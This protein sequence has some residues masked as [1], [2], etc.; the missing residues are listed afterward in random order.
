MKYRNNKPI[1]FIGGLIIIV[2]LSLLV[3]FIQ[4]KQH[5]VQ[6]VDSLQKRSSM[7]EEQLQE[8]EDIRY[9]RNYILFTGDTSAYKELYITYYGLHN[10]PYS[11]YLADHCNYPYACYNVYEEISERF[12]DLEDP[13]LQTKA[14]Q[15]A[16]FY[17]KKGAMLK[18]R[19]CARILAGMYLKGDHV[20][21]DTVIG[22][23]YLIQAEGPKLAEIEYKRI[24]NTDY[25]WFLQK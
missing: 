14:I 17:L 10:L 25:S 2:L 12:D 21:Q 9:F 23:E 19:Q 18:D 16:I 24:K 8:R 4:K 20:P 1:I 11:I 5:L 22:R 15:M 13:N 7:L 6:E 3:I